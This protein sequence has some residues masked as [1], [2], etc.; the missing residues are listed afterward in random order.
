ML[1][2]GSLLI[3]FCPERCLLLYYAFLHLF[4]PGFLMYFNYMYFAYIY[5]SCFSSSSHFSWQIIL[6]LDY[7]FVLQIFEGAL[8]GKGLWSRFM[9]ITCN[10]SRKFQ[11][12]P[13]YPGLIHWYTFS[14]FR[15]LSYLSHISFH[16]ILLPF[17]LFLSYS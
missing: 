14:F 7:L 5:S 4:S 8:F 10:F 2:L 13:L 11:I 12:F 1:I 9:P 16:L 6:R 15:V 17:H 3:D